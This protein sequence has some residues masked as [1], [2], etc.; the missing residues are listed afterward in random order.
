MEHFTILVIQKF[1]VVDINL[2][3]HSRSSETTWFDLHC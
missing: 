2:Q 3:G 1:S